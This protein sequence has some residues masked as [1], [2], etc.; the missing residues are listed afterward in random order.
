MCDFWQVLWL[1]FLRLSF[2]M[3]G[4]VDASRGQAMNAPGGGV[5]P[6]SEERSLDHAGAVRLRGSWSDG[7]LGEEG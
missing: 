1:Y 2:G 4:A 6:E 3:G 7:S 5:S